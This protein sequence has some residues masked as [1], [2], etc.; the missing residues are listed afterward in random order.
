MGREKMRINFP[1]KR[2]GVAYYQ[3]EKLDCVD[4]Y[5]EMLILMNCEIIYQCRPCSHLLKWVVKLLFKKWDTIRFIEI[6]EAFFLAM[7]YKDFIP[8]NI[9][10]QHFEEHK[11][12]LK[13][14][15]YKA[16]IE[17]NPHE[18]IWRHI[19]FF[20]ES[21][22]KYMYARNFIYNGIASYIDI[23]NVNDFKNDLVID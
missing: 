16:K 10:L 20:S 4:L 15:P 19:D 17:K 5:M 22:K 12:L 8:R 1:Q 6:E 11:F 18:L 7:I 9:V 21:I 14:I 2:F 3:Y 23:Y 13:T